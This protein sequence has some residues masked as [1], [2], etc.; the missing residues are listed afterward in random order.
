MEIVDSV[1]ASGQRFDDWSFGGGTVLMRRFRHRISKDIDI[2]VPDPQ[3]L[4]YVSPRLNDVAEGISSSYMET[5]I[6]VKLYFPDGEIDFIAS[7]PLTEGPTTVETVL[8]RRIHVQTTAEIVAK[9]V[10]HRGRDLTARDMFDLAL[11]AAR[12]PAAIERIAG[13][14][15]ERR[16]VIRQRIASSEKILRKTYSELD[17]LDFHPSFDECLEVVADLLDRS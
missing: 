13:I 14:L 12:E 15:R 17:T 1:A 10:W 8:G 11:V 9:K 6:S 7:A 4:G 3:Y 5:A 2:F 16:E